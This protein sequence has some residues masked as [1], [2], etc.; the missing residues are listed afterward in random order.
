MNEDVS[1][2]QQVEV[3]GDGAGQRILDRNDSCLDRAILDA[4]EDLGRAGTWNNCRLRQHLA[5]RFMTE[6]AELSLNRN[7]HRM[8]REYQKLVSLRAGLPATQQ[9]LR[10]S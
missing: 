4:I 8:R 6:R 1:R 9:F 3:F 2:E 7:F 10:D 5:R